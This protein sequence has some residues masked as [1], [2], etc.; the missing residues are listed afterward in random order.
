MGRRCFAS[1][2]CEVSSVTSVRLC[3]REKL[4]QAMYKLRRE[5]R[6]PHRR[7]RV[8]RLSTGVRFV[9]RDGGPP[10]GIYIDPLVSDVYFRV[11]SGFW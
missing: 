6:G 4:G 3:S 7:G 5:A 11:L 1:E 9:R 8:R 10:N 2:S